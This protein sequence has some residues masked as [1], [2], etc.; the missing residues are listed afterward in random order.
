MKRQTYTPKKQPVYP[1]DQ[2]ATVSK[3]RIAETCYQ[4]LAQRDLKRY[5]RIIPIEEQ[6]P[7]RKNLTSR[8][9]WRHSVR[10]LV[11]HAP[12]VKV[13]VKKLR[14]SELKL[15]ASHQLASRRRTGARCE[16]K[17]TAKGR[18]RIHYGSWS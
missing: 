10:A 18:L 3:E 5:G 1:S 7:K 17:Q 14:K 9:G 11:R 12:N 6:L 13:N 4:V 2:P 16:I 15:L 8:D